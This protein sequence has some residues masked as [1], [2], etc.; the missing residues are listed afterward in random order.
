ML[1]NL[2]INNKQIIY[3]EWSG[4]GSD[5]MPILDYTL[6]ILSVW[7]FSSEIGHRGA[8]VLNWG[9]AGASMY[10]TVQVNTVESLGYS[11]VVL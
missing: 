2:F 8:T 11:S 4:F 7:F 3:I 9:Q 6:P 1:G 10:S 5:K